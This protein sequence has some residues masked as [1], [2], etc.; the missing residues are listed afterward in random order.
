MK[1]VFLLVVASCGGQTQLPKGP[2]PE[3]E[4]EPI[5][6]QQQDAA[7]APSAPVDAGGP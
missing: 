4:D 7:P 6:T 1:L 5:V 3:Y 2:P